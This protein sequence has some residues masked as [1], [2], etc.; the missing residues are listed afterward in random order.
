MGLFYDIFFLYELT[1]NSF[2]RNWTIQMLIH[3]ISQFVGSSPML[4]SHNA[5][6]CP[7]VSVGKFENPAG[8]SSV[9]GGIFVLLNLRHGL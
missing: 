9:A 5:C 3:L 4:S 1:A 2:G 7:S 6:E 8:N